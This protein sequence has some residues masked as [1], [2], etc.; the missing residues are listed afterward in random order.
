MFTGQIYDKKASLLRL[1][2]SVDRSNYSLYSGF[3]NHK[4][5]CKNY[6]QPRN[7][8]SLV[9]QGD[10]PLRTDIESKLQNRHVPLNRENVTYL[11]YAAAGNLLDNDKECK[12]FHDKVYDIAP[13]SQYTLLSHPKV[14]YR[15]VECADKHIL[16]Y[17]IVDKQKAISTS[18]DS[19]FYSTQNGFS[20]S[21]PI[22]TREIMR[23]TNFKYSKSKKLKC[24]DSGKKYKGISNCTKISD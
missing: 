7:T 15:G 14:N 24:L 12:G 18:G 1:K 23:N 4:N 20:F 13:S 17:M 22:N 3:S 11:D 8:R 21:R 6:I 2:K 16:P 10:L 9:K 5:Q 19:P